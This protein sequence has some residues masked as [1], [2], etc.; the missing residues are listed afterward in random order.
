M[1]RGKFKKYIV[2]A[3]LIGLPAVLSFGPVQS[4][5]STAVTELQN[6]FQ[7]DVTEAAQSTSV[8]IRLEMWYLSGMYILDNPLK[9]YGN[10][11][12]SDVF[13]E[14]IIDE[15]SPRS[16]NQFHHVHSDILQSFLS[17]GV[18]GVLVYLLLIFYPIWIAYRND[19]VNKETI[20]V[21][22]TAFF[23]TGLSDVVLIKAVSQ[24][25]YL[26]VVTLMLIPG[27]KPEQNG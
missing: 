11:P 17:R 18:F 13:S 22:S 4:R 25:F 10:K 3:L 20:A 14:Q 6:Y 23:L 15:S 9:G 19:L 1:A 8:G 16:L 27:S 2:I 24:V 5:I 26:A 12:L 21:F 7:A